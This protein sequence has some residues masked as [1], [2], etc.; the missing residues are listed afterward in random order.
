MSDETGEPSPLTVEDL[1]RLEQAIRRCAGDAGPLDETTFRF[2]RMA[3]ANRRDLL[4]GIGS[5]IH[6]Q[7]WNPRGV[8]TVY[9]SLDE[10]TAVAE[11]FEAS[12]AN[13]LPVSE[14]TPS[15]IAAIRVSLDR[16]LDLTAVGVA[17]VLDPLGF[18][19]E[20][21][22]REPWRR[23]IDSAELG[24][25]IEIGRLCHGLGIQAIV[26]PSKP[27]PGGRNLAIY[28]DHCPPGSLRI[29]NEG[30]LPAPMP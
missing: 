12:R 23:R 19:A 11:A 17:G 21:M 4:S 6:G 1:G 25:T 5:A 13:G 27:R 2:A 20:R 16:V 15:V 10:M 9:T 14:A 28:V 24:P 18:T 26:V 3:R 7:R 29:V 8:R 30:D 22:A